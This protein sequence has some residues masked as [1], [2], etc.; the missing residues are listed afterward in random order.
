MSTFLDMKSQ[1][2]YL[3][4]IIG[5]MFSGKTSKLLQLYKQCKYCNIPVKIINHKIDNRYSTYELSSHDQIKAPCDFS[6]TLLDLDIYNNHYNVILINEGQFFDDLYEAVEKL[7]ILGKQ[8]Y[9]CGLDGDFQRKKFGQI[10]DLIPLCD[11]VTKLKSL[12]TKCKNGTEA[13][14]S[15]RITSELE[16]TVVGSDNY[17]PVCRKCYDKKIESDYKIIYEKFNINSKIPIHGKFNNFVLSYKLMD[18][19]IIRIK[20]KE[21]LDFWLEIEMD[22]FKNENKNSLF[23]ENGDIETNSDKI[24]GSNGSEKMIYSFYCDSKYL[25]VKSINKQLDFW[26]GL[27]FN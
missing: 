8:I 27:C 5:P 10:L 23:I 6:E 7:L 14:F 18:N 24:Y 3:E 25:L 1:S 2:P 19:N 15:Q 21:K 22:Y 12:C 26:V 20:C 13:I 4:L 16:Q 11:N 17:I 9:I